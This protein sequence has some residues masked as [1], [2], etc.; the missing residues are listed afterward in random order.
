M[1]TMT[2]LTLDLALRII[3]GAFAKAA[4]TQCAP[5]T[6]VVLD[7]GGHEVALQRQDRSG[8]LRADIARAKAWGALGMG[9]AS[10]EIGERAQKAP[11]FFG[12]L[13][14]VAQ[15]R[16]TP[17]A[18]GLLIHDEEKNVIGAVG[19]SGDTSDRDEE[20]AKAGLVAAGLQ[21]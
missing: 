17:A 5:L 19:I 6:V 8:I 2:R 7:A 16:L 12:A 13:A 10:R 15:G 4:E 18:G 21:K 9:Y 3:G 20:C 14:S 11:A 1:P